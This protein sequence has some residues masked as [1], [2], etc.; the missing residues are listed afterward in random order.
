MVSFR[1]DSG[2]SFSSFKLSSRLKKIGGSEKSGRILKYWDK[3]RSEEAQAPRGELDLVDMEQLINI[4]DL[5]EEERSGD[6]I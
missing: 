5:V 3:E 1:P 6:K 4:D 2:M